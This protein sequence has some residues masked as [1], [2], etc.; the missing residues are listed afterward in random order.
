[1]ACRL[2]IVPRRD[3]TLQR[4]L[5]RVL[6]IAVGLVTL[7]S[8]GILVSRTLEFS[9]GN[10]ATLPTDLRPALLVTHF[11]HIWRWRI[12]AVIVL[13]LA[14]WWGRRHAAPAIW[15]GWLMALA[16]ALI[17]LTRSDTGHPADAGDFTVAVWVDWL[18]LLAAGT[19]VGSLFGMT[20][21]VFPRLSRHGPDAVVPAA[22]IFQRLSTVCGVALAVVLAAG[23]YSALL[24]LDTFADLWTT[25]YGLALD[26]KITLVLV[27][28]LI[29]AHNR[30]VKLPRLKYAARPADTQPSHGASS[31]VPSSHTQGVVRTCARAVLVES[32]L[33]LA[34]IGAAACLIHSMPPADMR[35]L[36]AASAPTHDPVAR[37][38][39][40]PSPL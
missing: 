7:A 27:M 34:V 20:L 18:H 21:V 11:G 22:N 37:H 24:Q 10:W 13:W 29:G 17:A 38:G 36:P 9:G 14:W 3:V 6:G 23:V 5:T 39:N 25:R 2:T 32:V 28:I 15:N 35:A 30:Y 1:M 4:P 19:W 33:G 31:Y 26:V 40:F 8:V 16:L 12:A